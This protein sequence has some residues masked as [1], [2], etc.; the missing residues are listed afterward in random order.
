MKEKLH[1]NLQ[2][3]IFLL[4]RI[5]LYWFYLL[6]VAKKWCKNHSNI[7]LWQPLV[8]EPMNAILFDLGRLRT[9]GWPRVW[10]AGLGAPIWL[11]LSRAAAGDKSRNMSVSVEAET[12]APDL[13]DLVTKRDQNE[14]VWDHQFTVKKTHNKNK[15]T[16]LYE[17]I[18]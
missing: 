8:D 13:H 18:W 1:E 16:D 3:C 7:E 6:Y 10:Q 9:F 4:Q 15:D 2:I 14:F 11:Q 5:F 17:L 12:Q